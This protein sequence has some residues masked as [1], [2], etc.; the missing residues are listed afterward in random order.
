MLRF[1]WELFST[2]TA[3]KAFYEVVNMVYMQGHLKQV[4]RRVIYKSLQNVLLL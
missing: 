3:K 4:G 2:I 1:I